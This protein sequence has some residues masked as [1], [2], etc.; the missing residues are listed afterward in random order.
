MFD[1]RAAFPMPAPRA[2]TEDPS[3]GEDR[4]DEL[5]KATIGAVGEDASMVLAHRLDR[6]VAVVNGI[7]AV[8]RATARN[9]DDAQVRVCDEELRVTGPSIV[10]GFR[11]CTVI[12]CGYEGAIE[13][14]GATTVRDSGRL[15]RRESSAQ[16]RDDAMDWGLRDRE[17]RRELAEREVGPQRDAEHEDADTQWAHPRPASAARFGRRDRGDDAIELARAETSQPQET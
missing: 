3:P 15:D 11:G 7:V 17:Y 16:V 10:L 12:T 13:D 8:A 6:R 14:P 2:I 9:R 4:R 1:A 5:L